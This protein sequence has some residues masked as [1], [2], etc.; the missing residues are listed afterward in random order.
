M[1][2]LLLLLLLSIEV[3]VVLASAVGILSRHCGIQVGPHAGR[4]ERE[5]GN[6]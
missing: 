4:N 1:L 2:L 5:T 3:Y 6:R